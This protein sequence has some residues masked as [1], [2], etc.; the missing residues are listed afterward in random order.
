MADKPIV[1]W[2]GEYGTLDDAEADYAAVMDLH[3]AGTLGKVAAALVA[4]DADGKLKIHRH[5]TSTAVGAWSG[6]V[7]GALLGVLV[8]PLGAFALTGSV[9][10]GLAVGAGVDAAIVGGLGGVMGHFWKGIPKDDIRMMGDALEAGQAGLLVVADDKAV[11]D[12]DK[13]ITRAD[14]KMSKALA[15]GDIDKAYDEAMKAMNKVD[16]MAS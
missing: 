4:K 9:V 5:N 15:D 3:R 16:R 8:P 14:R 12:I 1:I 10:G 2:V 6:V 7:I 13:V 11:E